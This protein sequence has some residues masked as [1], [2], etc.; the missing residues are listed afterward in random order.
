[1]PRAPFYW[2][3]RLRIVGTSGAQPSIMRLDFSYR[4]IAIELIVW[5][6]LT[7]LVSR[8]IANQAIALTPT[9][10]VPRRGY[11]AGMI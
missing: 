2:L 1:M 5:I 8:R 11:I 10:I 7:S 6:V 4:F 9:A 3:F